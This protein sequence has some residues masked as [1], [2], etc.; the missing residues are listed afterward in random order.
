MACGCQ[1]FQS[2]DFVV[3]TFDGFHRNLLQGQAFDI[4]PVNARSRNLILARLLRR[5]NDPEPKYRCISGRGMALRNSIRNPLSESEGP[6][7]LNNSIPA[8]FNIFYEFQRL[9]AQSFHDQGDPFGIRMQPVW[10]HQ[11]VHGV[12]TVGLDRNRA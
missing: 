8:S 7:R 6:R 2:G 5:S 12:F 9:R 4:Q 11:R 3:D 1:I 10:L